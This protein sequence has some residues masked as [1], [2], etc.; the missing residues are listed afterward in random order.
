MAA[1]IAETVDL[2]PAKADLRGACPF[3][4]D[5][6]RGLYVSP[7]GH[8]HCYACSMAGDVVAWTMRVQGVDEA[9]A[10]SLLLR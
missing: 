10:I 3:H 5:V 4:P 7:T 9:T 1:L 2:R 8:F 6:D